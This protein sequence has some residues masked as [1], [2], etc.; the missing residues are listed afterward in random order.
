MVD[1]DSVNKRG[2][3]EG[4]FTFTISLDRGDKCLLA[5]KEIALIKFNR[6]TLL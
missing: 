2:Y 6:N 5:L 4:L 1:P 3:L